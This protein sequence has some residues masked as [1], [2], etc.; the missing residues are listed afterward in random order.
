MA[1]DGLNTAVNSSGDQR[2]AVNRKNIVTLVREWPL[3]RKVALG[4]ITAL[5]IGLF[6][7]LI[8]QARVADYQ[9][10]YANLSEA[11]AGSVV[12]WLKTQNIPYQLKNGGKNIWVG[13][14]KIY[15][16]RLDLAANGLPSGGD[17]G[18]EIFD[19]QSFAGQSSGEKK[20]ADLWSSQ[21]RS[22]PAMESEARAGSPR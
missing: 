18:F 19:K 2:T 11:D 5:S 1:T 20:I 14:D 12:N 9:L 8:I 13:A 16:T 4:V 15:D 3:N 17:V 10:L 21:T 22:L 7:F 6:A